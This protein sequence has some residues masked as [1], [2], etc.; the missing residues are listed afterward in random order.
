LL[1]LFLLTS[2]YIG[3]LQQHRGS[4]GKWKVLGMLFNTS[5]KKYHRKVEKQDGN[6]NLVIED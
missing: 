3:Q 4:P 6:S 2:S 1:T 5:K